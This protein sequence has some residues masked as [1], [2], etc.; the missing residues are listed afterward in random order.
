[1]LDHSSHC[2]ALVH[3]MLL[4]I[5]HLYQ[6][7]AG[8]FSSSK[9]LT[10]PCHK[11][12]TAF[13]VSG[14]M[15]QRSQSLCKFLHQLLQQVPARLVS[16][17]LRLTQVQ[18]HYLDPAPLAIIG[19]ESAGLRLPVACV[20]HL[21]RCGHPTRVLAMLLSSHAMSDSVRTANIN[22]ESANAS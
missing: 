13:K 16:L 8:F 12:C 4:F 21:L 2:K 15:M 19:T 14:T 6:Q 18:T 1:M 3:M 10:L 5:A 11:A 9:T 22:M 17:P 7:H 20:Q